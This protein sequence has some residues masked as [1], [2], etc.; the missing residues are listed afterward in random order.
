[1]NKEELITRISSKSGVVKKDTLNIF[2]A[3]AAI[4][5]DSVAAGEKVQIIGFGTFE[6]RI[7]KERTGHNPATGEEIAIPEKKIPAF[8]P[9]KEFKELV[10]RK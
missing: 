8:K 7:R 3:M 5:K 2:N 1:M 4:I 9:S 6:A 10:N